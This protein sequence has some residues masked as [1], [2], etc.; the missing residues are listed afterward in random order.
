MKKNLI[1]CISGKNLFKV[2]FNVF[3]T[4]VNLNVV[5]SRSP[6]FILFSL[7]DIKEQLHLFF[8]LTV[9]GCLVILYDHCSVA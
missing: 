9:F 6:I 8:L 5:L 2:C 4:N 3:Y 1:D 7:L